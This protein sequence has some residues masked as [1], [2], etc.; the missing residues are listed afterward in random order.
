[1]S[2]GEEEPSGAVES[3]TLEIFKIHLGKVKGN[4]L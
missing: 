3:L 1:M 4:L 2:E